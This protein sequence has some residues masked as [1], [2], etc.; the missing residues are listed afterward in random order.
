MLSHKGQHMKYLIYLLPH[1]NTAMPGLSQSTVHKLMP[2]QMKSTVQTAYALCERKS[3]L[4]LHNIQSEH[5]KRKP[6][7]WRSVFSH[8]SVVSVILCLL[9]PHYVCGTTKNYTLM[10]N[11]KHLKDRGL[12]SFSG[13]MAGEHLLKMKK[14]GKAL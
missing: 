10:V 2:I 1:T 4:W 8:S 14:R 12:S 9:Y 11:L 13:K 6:G 7:I 5:L 3:F